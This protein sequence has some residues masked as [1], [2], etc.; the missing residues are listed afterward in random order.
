MLELLLTKFYYFIWILLTPFIPLITIYR[1]LNRKEEVHKI[2]EKF[3]LSN[4]KRPKGNLIW[5]NAASLGEARSAIPLIKEILKYDVKILFTTVTITSAKHIKSILE[6][7]NN[8]NII[9]QYSPIDHP[10]VLWLFYKNWK[11]NS[12]IL[13]ES[14]IWPNI[15]IKSFK[16]N[17]PI[18]LIQGRMSSKSYK[19]WHIFKKF[20]EN[21]FTKLSLVIAQDNQNS[22]RYKKLGA[23]N[24]LPAINLKNKLN[25]PKMPNNKEKD[26]IKS[27]NNKLVLLF[28]SIHED[29]EDEATILTHMKAKEI[30]PKLITIVV[31][32]HPNNIKNLL[33]LSKTKNLN[34]IVRSSL[35]LPN[36]STDIYIVDTIGELGSFYKISSICFIGGSLSN[37]G[38]HNLIEPALE[39]CAIIF[40]PDVSNQKSTSKILLDNKCAIQI[41]SLDELENTIIDLI[42]NK[43][44]INYLANKAYEIIEEIPSPANTLMDKIKPIL[45]I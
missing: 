29:I 3:G 31:P 16:N 14:E 5:I 40:G 41:N 9:H 11:P 39:K 19:K 42:S 44:K 28:A 7:I 21:L 1:I 33:N 17:I 34:V 27:I 15:I 2:T 45:K 25:A 30:Y 10:F 26:I 8:K 35:N 20:S 43:E 13:V 37:K 24:I 18:I 22:E 32:R 6:D 36:A 4:Y 38:G 12:V 23:K